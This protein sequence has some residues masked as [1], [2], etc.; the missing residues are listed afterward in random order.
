MPGLSGSSNFRKELVEMRSETSVDRGNV[1]GGCCQARSL[2][3]SPTGAVAVTTERLSD[4]CVESGSASAVGA[5]AACVRCKKTRDVRGAA[6]Q[7]I[8]QRWDVRVSI[9]TTVKTQIRGETG[10]SVKCLDEGHP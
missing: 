3:S 7:T 1:V 10:W 8:R 6:T 2:P 4:L 9:L 5:H